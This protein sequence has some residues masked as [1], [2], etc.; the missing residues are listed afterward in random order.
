MASFEVAKELYLDAI[1][2]N[3]IGLLNQKNLHGIIKFMIC[4]DVLCHEVKVDG[5]VIDV[6]VDDTIYEIQSA[7]FRL[8]RDKITKFTE[9]YPMKIIFPIVVK[10]QIQW[11]DQEKGIQSKRVSPKKGK[12]HDVLRELYQI[13]DCL[14]NDNLSIECYFFDVDEV[15]ILDG[16][17][18]TKRKGAT[19]VDRWPSC[20]HHKITLNQPEDYRQF[21]P[22]DLPEQF[23]SKQI[24]NLLKI[25]ERQSSALLLILQDFNI[26]ERVGK[27]GRAYLYRII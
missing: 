20:F 7:Q 24:R 27:E 21:L 18:A 9:Q 6:F 4:D 17:D 13:R 22:H 15:R 2:Q 8:L 11:L 1:N 14:N 19:K 23:N 10:K 5:K 26:I 3:S 16:W 25:N 12:L